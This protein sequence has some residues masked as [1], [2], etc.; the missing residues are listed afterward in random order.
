MW[1]A[2][3]IPSVI[4]NYMLY[5]INTTFVAYA[6]VNTCLQPLIPIAKTRTMI[7]KAQDIIEWFSNLI[8]W[9]LA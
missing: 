2:T 1:Y 6:Q 3:I 5:L 8:K 4:S 9:K 7:I